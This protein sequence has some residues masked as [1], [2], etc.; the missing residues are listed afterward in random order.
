MN[1]NLQSKR[2]RRMVLAAALGLCIPTATTVNIVQADDEWEESTRYYEDDA[3]YDVSE[4]FDG[5]DYNPTDEAL[6]RWDN[7]TWDASDEMTDSDSDSDVDW[8]DAD[9]GYY[10]DNDD[11]W[12]YDYYD[13]GYADYGDY[14]YDDTFDYTA[15]YYD[16]DDDGIYD[17]FASYTDTDGD[18]FYDDMN[19]YAFS[20][21]N[22]SNSDQAKKSME[23]ARQNQKSQRSKMTSFTGTIKKAKKVKT[24]ASTNVVAQL[25]DS[26]SGKT[27]L[28]DMGPADGFD[29]MPRIGQSV[30]AKGVPY[31]AG[32]KTVL[33]A[34]KLERNG[35]TETIDRSGREYTGTIDKTLTSKIR[36]Q[37][38]TL[39]KVTTDTGK[40]LL[41]DMGPSK[42]LK[43][44]LNKG[45]SVTLKGPAV[46]VNNRLMLIA[47]EVETNGKS[48][49]IQRTA[50]K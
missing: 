2:R 36:G 21:A 43:G 11:D 48:M 35:A 10:A 47:T 45:N 9:Y 17:A 25:S 44:D 50:T 19:Y 32:D 28:V 39:A 5:N 6:T 22:S 4:W 8:S 40:A 24:P 26:S 38:H 7:E 37:E 27:M 23:D 20:D 42:S 33:L 18:G 15:S 12:Y 13:Y 34:Q 3:W 1:K 31:K 16:Y 41:V 29:E 49:E 14:D 46:K 30:M